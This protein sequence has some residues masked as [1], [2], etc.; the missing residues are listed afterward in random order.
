MKAFR[1]DDQPVP[2]GAVDISVCTLPAALCDA[3]PEATGPST[4]GRLV[5]QPGA[6][7]YCCFD[8]PSRVL[9]EARASAARIS[10]MC[11]GAMVG[12]LAPFGCVSGFRH[13]TGSGMPERAVAGR[14]PETSRS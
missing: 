1:R 4:W 5:S 14:P 12:L 13:S 11:L 9:H 2:A 7:H 6:T 3:Y 10:T 8:E